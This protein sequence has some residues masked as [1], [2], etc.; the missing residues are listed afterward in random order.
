MCVG[1]APGVRGQC[2][3]CHHECAQVCFGCAPNEAR[4]RTGWSELFRAETS[5][6]GRRR[7]Y[8]GPAHIRQALAR[9]GA[10]AGAP[11]GRRAGLRD[12]GGRRCRRRHGN[13]V[14]ALVGYLRGHEGRAPMRGALVS[15]AAGRA[16]AR[17]AVSCAEA[18]RAAR[19]RA[20]TPANRRA[21][22]PHARRPDRDTSATAVCLAGRSSVRG[23]RPSGAPAR[24]NAH[25]APHARR[26]DPGHFCSRSVP[27]RAL[28]RAWACGRSRSVGAG[29][30][31]RP[32]CAA[33]WGG[34]ARGGQSPARDDPSDVSRRKET[35]CHS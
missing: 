15:C 10:G 25:V 2:A 27:R 34:R 9:G 13:A 12:G 18:G 24:G 6:S 7:G 28:F 17:G 33:G 4:R 14:A 21:G 8:S 16:R 22:G 31:V 20:Y 3:S 30:V 23:R 5:Y 29:P 19:P 26:P 35:M 1:C 11:A 32:R